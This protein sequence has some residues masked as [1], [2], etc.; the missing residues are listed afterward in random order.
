MSD[1]EESAPVAASTAPAADVDTTKPDTETA[2]DEKSAAA[3]KP[4]ESEPTKE[5]GA[6]TAEGKQSLSCS[7]LLGIPLS[8]LHYLFRCL[9]NSNYIHTDGG[10]P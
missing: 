1:K 8:L 10:A 6:K 2:G 7:P 4:T 5:E 9:F 3:A